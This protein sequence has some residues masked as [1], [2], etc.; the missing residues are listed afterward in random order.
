MTVILVTLVY[1]FHPS[2]HTFPWHTHHQP[3]LLN[4]LR[5]VILATIITNTHQLS[6][7]P[8]THHH[9]HPP[10][11][12]PSTHTAL[13]LL[14]PIYIYTTRR[15]FLILDPTTLYVQH[16]NKPLFYWDQHTRPTSPPPTNLSRH[17][18]HHNDHHEHHS[19]TTTR[20]VHFSPPPSIAVST[21]TV[22]SK[23]RPLSQLTNLHTTTPYTHT[24][25]SPPLIPYHIPHL[26]PLP[27]PH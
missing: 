6:P 24:P 2:L 22:S 12:P 26:A 18:A 13:H 14:S 8:S 16:H 25:P 4:S 10:R 21:T 20:P 1:F 3:A 17:F 11:A 15:M 19:P 23:S 27:I 9:A 5:Q 7:S